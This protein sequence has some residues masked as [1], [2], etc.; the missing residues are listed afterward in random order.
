[1]DPEFVDGSIAVSDGAQGPSAVPLPTLPGLTSPSASDT[2]VELTLGQLAELI[3]THQRALARLNPCTGEQCAEIVTIQR[4]LQL[5]LAEFRRRAAKE[6]EAKP[7]RWRVRRMLP[8]DVLDFHVPP[9]HRKYAGALVRT[10][11][12]AFIHGLKPFHIETLRPQY[13]FNIA[14][15]EVLDELLRKVAYERP[16]LPGYIRQKFA[17]LA[18][19]VSWNVRSHRKGPVAEA[20]NF[21]KRQYLSAVSPLVDD[22]FAAQHRWNLAAVDALVQSAQSA[23]IPV[24]EADK[25]IERLKA[26]MD[27]FESSGASG[28]QIL[29]PLLREVFRKQ[30]VFNQEATGRIASLLTDSNPLFDYEVWSF[31]REHQQF[32]DAT[33][34][35]AA[36][37]R[38]PLISIVTPVF[39][40]PP[41][42]LRACIDSVLKQSYRNWELCLIDDGSPQ[43]D[44]GETLAL[45][46]RK[47]SRITFR[48]LSNNS[49]IAHATNAGLRLARGEYV[50]FLDHDDILAP[51]ALAELAWC[52]AEKSPDLIYSDEDRIDM[53]GRRS[54]PFFKPD[55]SPDLLRAGNYLCHLVAVRREILDQVG[56]LRE[57]FE[58]AQDYDFLLRV[59][60]K[61]QRI[62]HIPRILYHWRLWG[63]S[64]SQSTQKLK[65]ASDAGCRALSEHLQRCGETGLVS[66]DTATSYRIR[67]PVRNNPLVSII[68]PFKDKPHFLER[69]I[70]GLLHRTSFQNFE[71]LLIS[72]NS[73]E[74][75]TLTFLDSIDDRRI[76]KLRW[77]KPFNYPAINNFG[78]RL[79][80]GDLFLFLNNDMEIIQPGWLEELVGQAQRP[81]VGAVGAKLLFPDGRVQ[82]AGV[83]LGI[84]GFAGH[85][86]WKT[87]DLVWTPFGTAGQWT[88]NFLAVTSACLMIRREEFEAVRG[89]DE[90]FILCG[91]DVDIGLRLVERG[92]RIVYTPHASLIHHESASRSA[93]AVPAND[94]WMSFIS[95]RKWLR[96]G[97]PYYNP[98][99]SLLD[100]ACNLR[101]D[102]R[103]AETLAVQ[104]LSDWM[105]VSDSVS[106]GRAQQQRHIA[107]HLLG[108][109]HSSEMSRQGRRTGPEKM[110]ALRKGR[111]LEQIAWF[112]PSFKHPYGGIHTILRFADRLRQR[113]G[114]TS[115]FF[116]YDN[117]HQNASELELRASSLYPAISGSFR[118][119][120]N[121]AE[122]AQLPNCDLAVATF[123]SSAYSVLQYSRAHASAYFVQDYEPLFYPAG[124]YYAAAE[125]TYNLGLYGIFNSQGLHDFITRN[126]PMSG[127][128]F[129]PSID[130]AVF[131]NRRTRGTGPVRLFFYGRPSTDRNAFEL[132]I[133]VL[134]RLKDELGAAIDI[135]SAGE[136]WTPEHYGLLGVVRNLGLLPY[137]K[138]AD[139][140]RSCDV[141]LCF[142]FTKHPSYLPLELMACGV[143]VVTNNNPA[144]TWLFEHERNCLLAE[145]TSTCVLEQLGR[146]ARDSYLRERLSAAGIKRVQK[147]TWEEQIDKVYDSLIEVQRTSALVTPHKSDRSGIRI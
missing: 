80:S 51:H 111:K 78:A 48:R 20:L 31:E 139:L 97:D 64:L 42:L 123:W 89:F 47:D 45:Y 74:P 71:V 68:V 88:R 134:R 117:P 126:Y 113:H 95:Y 115:S 41:A 18:S 25:Y 84:F 32:L 6:L 13:A 85:P 108:F 100:T 28:L 33:E 37:S 35:A 92:K 65:A 24:P 94:A 12:R 140:Y 79:A 87:H 26:S 137:E 125:Q 10:V 15:S 146:A 119:L 2:A 30:V 104:H 105:K 132:G 60:E 53:Q 138:T 145:P 63:D 106:L 130:R 43:G 56:G 49:G 135:V 110:S 14:L 103:D 3:A 131:H 141:G 27:P 34:A 81:E 36:L 75:E 61:A 21:C 16:D 121:D 70:D 128:W 38:K 9:S 46:A 23:E 67:Y 22:F 120:K 122:L 69:L 59:S 62:V 143:T 5:L 109:D 90:R 102:D 144:N 44:V 116:V 99:L 133:S 124:A 29:E 40:T 57:G 91:S 86:F 93:D 73:V 98:N 83:I 142:M 114:V 136:T 127:C 55:W 82:H 101:E 7:N 107:D 52:I 129:E 11:K 58:G 8:A 19:P 66:D 4:T 50:A 72:N 77:D 76:K 54:L 17:P 147:T 112:V 96:R 1:M 118:V 39:K